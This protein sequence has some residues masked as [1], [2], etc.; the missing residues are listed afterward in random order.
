MDF[1]SAMQ[2][3]RSREEVPDNVIT[4]AELAPEVLLAI[5]HFI[6]AGRCDEV[7]AALNRLVPSDL[8]Q[9]EHCMILAAAQRLVEQ[10]CPWELDA[11]R[12]ELAKRDPAQF[13]EYYLNA[14]LECPAPDDYPLS[15]AVD[16]LVASRALPQSQRVLAASMA[17]DLLDQRLRLCTAAASLAAFGLSARDHDRLLFE[18]IAAILHMFDDFPLGESRKHWQA[19]LARKD[20]ELLAIEQ[21]ALRDLKPHLE[22]IIAWGSRHATP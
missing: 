14:F 6:R 11:L 9:V 12:S 2:A 22:A 8:I 19:V 7:V 1:N 15:D 18:P 16:K 20:Q 4:Q 13:A 17:R 21:E 10:Q 3:M 5:L